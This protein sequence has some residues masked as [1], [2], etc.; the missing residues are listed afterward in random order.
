MA[1]KTYEDFVL[2]GVNS[3]K[4]YLNVSGVATSGY[5][6]VELVVRAFSASKMNIAIV[7]SSAQQ[8]Q[9][10]IKDYNKQFQKYGLSDPL[11]VPVSER[12][13]NI[14]DWPWINLGHIFGYILKTDFQRD[15]IGC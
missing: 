14:Y 10:L 6:Q 15:Y 7:M 8:K 5:S 3:I 12:T 9:S 11:K 2:L 1:C 13:T 4:S